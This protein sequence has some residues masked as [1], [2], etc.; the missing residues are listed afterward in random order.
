MSAPTLFLTF[1]LAFAALSPAPLAAWGVQGHEA[2]AAAA[3]EDLPPGVAAWF[4]G[5]EA[6]LRDHA[7]ELGHA[8]TPKSKVTS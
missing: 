8:I 1:V 7:G 3:L 2:A 5:Q 4:A 6:I